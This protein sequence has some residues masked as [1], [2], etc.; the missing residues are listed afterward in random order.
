[1]KHRNPGEFV[2][3]VRLTWPW[4]NAWDYTTLNSITS[5]LRILILGANWG[6]KPPI[7]LPNTIRHRTRKLQKNK[8]G[9]APHNRTSFCHTF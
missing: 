7:V 3:L 9:H 8:A 4:L 6:T 1:M 2:V 5:S